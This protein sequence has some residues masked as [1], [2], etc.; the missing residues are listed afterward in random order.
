VTG[1]TGGKGGGGAGQG[2]CPAPPRFGQ[3]VCCF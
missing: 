2:G 1:N 3:V